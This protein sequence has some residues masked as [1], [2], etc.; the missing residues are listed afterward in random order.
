MPT[1]TRFAPS[2]SG[3]LHLGGART[4]LFN[5]LYAKSN[6]GILRLRIEDSDKERSSKE[7]IDSI[8]NGLKWLGIDFSEPI[9][10]Q[11]NNHKRHIEVANQLLSN[12][13]AYK[14]FHDQNFI[15][16]NSSLKKKFKSEWRD[17]PANKHPKNQAYSIRL[18]SPVDGICKIE[19]KIQG[20]VEVKYEEIDDYIILRSDGSPTFL[21][22]SAVDD[23]DMKVTDIIRGDDH[24]TNSFRQKVILIF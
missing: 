10:F 16:N 20:M 12:N 13:L 17:I 19:D 15:K 3:S 2:P 24:L 14:C 22:S 7:S 4:A 5:Y 21:L 8:I 18:K 9:S 23:Y 1:I 11:T 6:D